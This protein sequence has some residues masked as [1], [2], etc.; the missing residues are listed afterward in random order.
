[1]Y[2]YA[3]E[4]LKVKDYTKYEEHLK[5]LN[6]MRASLQN[7]KSEGAPDNID[8]TVEEGKDMDDSNV[9]RLKRTYSL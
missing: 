9:I 5:K 2:L 7:R 6:Q 3:K 4:K 8:I 1:M